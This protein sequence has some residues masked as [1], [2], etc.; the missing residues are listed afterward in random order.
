MVAALERRSGEERAGSRRWRSCPSGLASDW[1]GGDCG[2]ASS[3]AAAGFHG[4]RWVGVRH[5][6]G[7]RAGLQHAGGRAG[8]RV[9]RHGR[10]GVCGLA[11]CGREGGSPWSLWGLR[12]C[13][14]RAGGQA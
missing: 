13:G 8:G 14:V 10:G 4:S 9:V 3:G 6:S 2:R 12:V 7:W 5:A 1:F 11:A